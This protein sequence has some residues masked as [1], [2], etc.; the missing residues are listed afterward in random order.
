[1]PG[2]RNNHSLLPVGDQGGQ[3]RGPQ[4]AG[5]PRPTGIDG[6]QDYGRID[7]LSRVTGSGITYRMVHSDAPG[8]DTGL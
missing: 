5:T 4:Q 8:V 7:P 1:M 2:T 6:P 3:T